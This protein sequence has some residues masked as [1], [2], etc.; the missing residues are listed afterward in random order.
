M[1]IKD[2]LKLYAFFVFLSI[3]VLFLGMAF[4]DSWEYFWY[5]AWRYEAGILGAFLL[6]PVFVWIFNKLFK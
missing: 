5:V 2:Y 6:T 4:T 1:N 3:V